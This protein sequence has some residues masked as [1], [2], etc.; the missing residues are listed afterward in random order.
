MNQPPPDNRQ[1]FT[2]VQA[3]IAQNYP[4]EQGEELLIRLRGRQRPLR[5]PVP[6]NLS[7]GAGGESAKPFEPSAYQLGILDALAGKCLKVEQLVAIVKDRP[8][9]YRDPGGIKELERHGLVAHDKRRGY[10]RPDA[11]PDEM[12]GSE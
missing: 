12:E 7:A 9:L 5:L 4:G 2:I 6:L 1:L 10:Y 8:K 11:M 3:W